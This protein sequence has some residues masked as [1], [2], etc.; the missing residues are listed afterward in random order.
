MIGNTG[1][2][3]LLDIGLVLLLEVGARPGRGLRVGARAARLL[4]EESG[5]LLLVTIMKEGG[6]SEGARGREE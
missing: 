1:E 4:P 6:G 2:S 3:I 5:V